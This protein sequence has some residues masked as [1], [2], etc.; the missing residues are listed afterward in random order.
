MCLFHY[1]HKIAT[2]RAVTNN[3]LYDQNFVTD[4]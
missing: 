3:G 1:G 4:D 2:G